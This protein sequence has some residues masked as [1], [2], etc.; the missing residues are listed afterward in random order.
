MSANNIRRYKWMSH[1]SHVTEEPS[2]R[3]IVSI[4]STDSISLNDQIGV[5]EANSIWG[6]LRGLESFSQMLVLTEDRMT[7]R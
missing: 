3:P 5:I 1:V 2:R 6:V 4:P 7:V